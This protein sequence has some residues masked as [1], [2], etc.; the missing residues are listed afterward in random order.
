MRK[1]CFLLVFLFF[2]GNLWANNHESLDYAHKV[3]G[4]LIKKYTAIMTEKKTP[5]D[6]FYRLMPADSVINSEEMMEFWWI[7]RHYKFEERR[8][9]KKIKEIY[10]TNF[11]LPLD[12]NYQWLINVYFA[13]F[14]KHSDKDDVIQNHFQNLTGYNIEVKGEITFFSEVAGVL[15]TVLFLYG[16][17][18]LFRK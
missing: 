11:T 3:V 1:I 9:A 14:F 10:D 7:V 6:D 15:F 13:G 17:A 18:I 5:I 2:A 12:T 4:E 8:H 16:V